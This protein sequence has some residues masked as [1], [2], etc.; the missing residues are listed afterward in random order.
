MGRKV[1]VAVCSLW[2][3]MIALGM[4]VVGR[5]VSRSG[6]DVGTLSHWPARSA[7]PRDDGRP[8]LLCFVHPRCPCTRATIRELERVVS[9]SPRAAVRIVF[10]DDPD[11]DVTSAATWSMAARVPGARRLRDPGGVEARRFGA[12]T[13]GLVM[14]FD[15]EGALRFR[16][17]VTSAR[18]HEG[19]SAGGAALEAALRGDRDAA[20]WARVFGCGL[21]DP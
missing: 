18:G 20:R 2:L 15:A 11:G 5:H 6:V 19:E 4:V 13:S 8:T 12:V 16:G 9:R 17:G 10:R 21:V 3:V 14:L 1:M 7:L